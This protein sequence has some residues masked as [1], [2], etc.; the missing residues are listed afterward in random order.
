VDPATKQYIGCYD[1]LQISKE[2]E[3][4]DS[5]LSW[6]PIAPSAIRYLRTNCAHCRNSGRWNDLGHDEAE[7]DNEKTKS[8]ERHSY[9][10][11]GGEEQLGGLEWI[12]TAV[13]TNGGLSVGEF[14]PG[15]RLERAGEDGDDSNLSSAD[16]ASKSETLPPPPIFALLDRSRT[17]S[18]ASHI[19][20]LHREVRKYKKGDGKA[21][22]L[23]HPFDVWLKDNFSHTDAPFCWTASR[24]ESGGIQTHKPANALFDI[25]KIKRTGYIFSWPDA[26]SK[27]SWT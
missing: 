1:S 20:A 9:A 26:Y 13:L 17:E 7:E 8:S 14:I 10:L 24:D 19:F 16:E 4:D 5:Y 3:E 21:L 11:L 18:T 2:N 23:L 25:G 27:E 12:R 15:K 22:H 6:G